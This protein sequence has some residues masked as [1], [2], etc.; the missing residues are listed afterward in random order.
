MR[1]PWDKIFV[2]LAWLYLLGV[3]VQFLLAG[4]II[5]DSGSPD[6]HEGLGWSIM[7][8][9]PVL[10][11]ILAFAAKFPSNLVIM[12]AVL[13]VIVLVQPFWASEFRDEFLGSMHV[14]GGMVI[15]LLS[16][17]I[18]QRATQ[19]VRS[20]SPGMNTTRRDAEAT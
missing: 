7:H 11:L 8:L 20:A 3:A 17:M 4:L 13:M 15:A 2:G 14:L 9:A 12:T 16:H 10:M 18:A 19:L 5:F 6:A 1:S